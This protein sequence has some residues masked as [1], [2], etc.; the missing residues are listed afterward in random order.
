ML[1]RIT[2]DLEHEEREAMQ[3]LARQELRGLKEQIRYVIRQ[4]VQQRG[5]LQM[6]QHPKEGERDAATIDA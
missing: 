6:N 2:L 5:L 3:V 1:T 4:E